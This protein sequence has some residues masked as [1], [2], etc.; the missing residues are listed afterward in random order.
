[1]KPNTTSYEKQGASTVVTALKIFGYSVLAGIM[2][3]FLYFSMTMISDGLFQEPKAYV[4]QEIV[5]GEIQEPVT[6]TPEEY[7]A[8]KAA[9]PDKYNVTDNS[10]IMATVTMGPKNDL[11]AA[12]LI[13][14]QI[15]TQALMLC[16]LTV[17][18][19]Y[20]VWQEGDRDRNLQDYH[21]RKPTPVRG[22][23]IGLIAGAPALAMFAVLLLSKFGI[24]PDSILGI[25][26]LLNAPFMPLV[27]IM[28]PVETASAA[29]LSAGQLLGFFAMQW[30][31]PVTC[32]VA[33]VIGCNRLL[34]PKGKK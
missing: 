32:A 23:W 31:V 29:A 3:L 27:N 21:D 24:V 20:Y 33:Y 4:V 26:R 8:D 22:V 6:L 34:K 28:V 15:L 14:A 12:L 2:C 18:T 13:G 30:Y 16:V 25:Y 7:A 17:M 19:G 9:N 1:M 10:R 5:D 11:C